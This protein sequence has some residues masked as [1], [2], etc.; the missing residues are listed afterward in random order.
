MVCV[1]MMRLYLYL[2]CGEVALVNQMIVQAEG[3]IKSA[4]SLIPDVPH[5]IEVNNVRK[6]T[7]EDLSAYLRNLSSFLLLFPGHPKHGPFYLVQGMLNA[8][9]AYQPWR[10]ASQHAAQVYLGVLSLFCTY[11]Q[12]SFPY[13]IDRVESNDMLYGGDIE[14]LTSARS[15]IEQI[16]ALL[17]NQLKQIGEKQDI[18]SRKIQGTIALDFVNLLISFM[19]MNSGSATLV[20]KLYGLAKKSEAVDEKYLASTFAHISNKKGTWYADITNKIL[21]IT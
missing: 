16:V 21:Q 17:F 2:Q 4:I 15:F 5:I 1:V 14:Y 3:F 10:E 12:R 7:E 13:H 9:E 20:V 18:L 19:Q 8:V 11:Y 6:S